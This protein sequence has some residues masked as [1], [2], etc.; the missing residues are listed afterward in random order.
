[1]FYV[2]DT[3]EERHKMIQSFYNEEQIC[4]A[5]L[6]A[7]ADFE[8]NIRRAI[9]ALGREP[10]KCIRKKLEECYGLGKYK[11]IWKEQIAKNP[12]YFITQE[13]DQYYL[14]KI[15]S[16]W[17]FFFKDAFKFRDRIIHGAST[18]ASL[19]YGKP[20]CESILNASQNIY[21]FAKS[22]GVDLYSRLPV[23]KMPK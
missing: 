15:I 18:S 16:N 13:S 9:I 20:R 12:K 2:S 17:Q 3:L 6:L 5:V 1:M 23:R 21:D 8:W 4:I 11:V 19:E 10:N 7:A 14:P 22:K